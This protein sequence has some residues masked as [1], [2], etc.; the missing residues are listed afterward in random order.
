MTDAKRVFD[1]E[2][3]CDAMAAT[4]GLSITA[5]QRPVVLQFLTIAAGMAAI[6]EAA[7]IDDASH[8]LA[9]VF[10]PALRPEALP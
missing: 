10:R 8:D 6:V 2:R 5:E 1:A 9:P 4:L 7:P 3:H